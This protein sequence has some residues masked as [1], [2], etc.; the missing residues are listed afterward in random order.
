M[1]FYDFSVHLQ[2]WS[3]T[4]QIFCSCFNCY[5]AADRNDIASDLLG[6]KGYPTKVIRHVWK[7]ELIPG[8]S[9]LL[10]RVVEFWGH[11]LFLPGGASV[12]SQ[13]ATMLWGNR[14][15]VHG[16]WKW[17][18][19]FGILS[20]KFQTPWNCSFQQ[21]QFF[22]LKLQQLHWKGSKMR[23]TLLQRVRNKW[24]SCVSQWTHAVELATCWKKSA[25][26]WKDLSWKDLSSCC[27]TIPVKTLS[28]AILASTETSLVSAEC[29]KRQK[30]PAILLRTNTIPRHLYWSKH[31]QFYSKVSPSFYRSLGLGWQQLTVG[32]TAMTI[33]C[34]LQ[35]NQ[36]RMLGVLAAWPSFMWPPFFNHKD[37]R[38]K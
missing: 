7:R 5:T 32:W 22:L 38:Y 30:N 8:L 14:R 31:W 28:A 12:L 21:K 13:Q 6:T 27:S 18:E 26:C 20:W 2:C 19:E 36:T 24:Q 11:P 9:H 29:K 34:M 37:H 17:L 23:K 4:H 15:H 1:T 10:H 25:L 3:L 33:F 35:W 16:K